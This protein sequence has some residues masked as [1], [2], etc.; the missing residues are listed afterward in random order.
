MTSDSLFKGKRV[1]LFALPGAFTPIC[2]STHLPG[3]EKNYAAIKAAGIDEIYCLSV[4]DVSRHP[5]LDVNRKCYLIYELTDI[6]RHRLLS[7]VNGAWHK[8]VRKRRL[9]Q[10]IH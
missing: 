3:Y 6:N 5:L 1:V 8:A 2:S 7:C 9:V 4:N 10:R